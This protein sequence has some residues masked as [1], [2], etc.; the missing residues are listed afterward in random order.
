MLVMFPIADVA[1]RDSGWKVALRSAS[2]PWVLVVAVTR[3]AS[4]D[5]WIDE[6]IDVWGIDRAEHDTWTGRATQGSTF[7]A[8]P[9]PLACPLLT[10]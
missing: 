6:H 7:C 10:C 8:C 2:S 1:G 4:A 5:G 3:S 9:G